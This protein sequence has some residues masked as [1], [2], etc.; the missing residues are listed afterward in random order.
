[1][2]TDT[3]SELQSQWYDSDGNQIHLVCDHHGCLI[4]VVTARPKISF[5]ELSTTE[6]YQDSKNQIVSFQLEILQ[7][8]T[9]SKGLAIG[10][11]HV[12]FL[13]VFQATG[14][15]NRHQFWLPSFLSRQKLKSCYFRLSGK[16]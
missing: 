5:D 3:E 16:E 7:Q 15:D 6:P 8:A 10:P 2:E 11:L 12:V 13:H 4:E 9:D 14:L 1:M